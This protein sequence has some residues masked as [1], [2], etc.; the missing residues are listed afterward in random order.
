MIL[1][2]FNLANKIQFFKIRYDSIFPSSYQLSVVPQLGMGLDVP[3]FC[4]WW[5]LVWLELVQV[6]Y[7]LNQLQW[8]Y[9]F[10]F[11]VVSRIH[12]LFVICHYICLLFY[13]YPWS[14]ERG[15]IVG[16]SHLELNILK[17]LSWFLLTNIMPP[18]IL[19]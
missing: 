3:F 10:N 8:V 1:L 11:T 9:I 12:S 13:K 17:Y 5:H 2:F 19:L 16:I 4:P 6:L 18:L 14:L 7:M 15:R